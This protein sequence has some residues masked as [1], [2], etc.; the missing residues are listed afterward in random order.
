MKLFSYPLNWLSLIFSRQSVLGD[1]CDRSATGL[2]ITGTEKN[3]ILIGTRYADTLNGG[4]GND[5]LLGKAGNDDLNGGDGR[6]WLFGNAGNDTLRG[7]RFIASEVSYDPNSNTEN[8]NTD[9]ILKLNRE[10]Q[11]ILIG[12]SGNDFLEGG[13]GKD[14]LIGGQGDDVL[15]GGYNAEE[16]VN[17]NYYPYELYEKSG[18]SNDLLIG[19]SGNDTLRGD[20]IFSDLSFT[21]LINFIGD[22]TL[23]GG[24]G[25]DLLEGGG[26]TDYLYGGSGNDR[27]FAN[28]EVFVVKNQLYNEDK[29]VVYGGSGDDYLEGSSGDDF[30]DGGSGNDT[31]F[32][33]DSDGNILGYGQ[34]T[35]I[36]GSGDDL[37]QGTLGN[38][39]LDGGAGNDVLI[40]KYFDF[41]FN[42]EFDTLTGGAGADIFVLKQGEVAVSE[43]GYSLVT[44]FE[45][46]QDIIQISN[47][48]ADF[49]E[50]GIAK[51]ILGSSPEGLPEGTGIY[52][53]LDTDI[54]IGIVQGVSGLSLDQ[55]YFRITDVLYS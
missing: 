20:S 9:E 7:D 29:D 11:D 46:S 32:G 16:G 2:Q 25:N 19:G 50:E 5:V 26:G 3:E 15:W 13:A 40:G 17:Y 6:D 27:L 8:S 42:E 31:L 54:L 44:D 52:L 1:V 35:L 47:Y 41:G 45:T 12:G 33:D 28:Y 10:G 43:K 4:A 39:I 36:G 53:D 37:L 38:D 30:L 22:D 49:S 24:S 23:Y 18:Y 48:S 21:N 55:S 51:Y 34:D 14:T